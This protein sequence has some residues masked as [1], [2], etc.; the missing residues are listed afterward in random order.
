MTYNIKISATAYAYVG[1]AKQN[2]TVPQCLCE[3]IDNAIAAAKPKAKTQVYVALAPCPQDKDHVMVCV[4]DWGTGMDVEGL[5][6]ALQLGSVPTGESRLNEHGFGLDNAL[7][8]LTSGDGN[9]SMMSHKE[10]SPYYMVTGPMQEDMTVEE[11]PQ[12]ELPDGILLPANPATVVCARVSMRFLQT[13]RRGGGRCSDLATV[14][15]W[16]LEHLGVAYRGYL[17]LDEETMEPTAKIVLSIGEDRIAVAPNPVPMDNVTT[18]RFS[19]EIAGAIV[20]MTYRYGML[21]E[22]AR[23]HMVRGTKA[24]YYYQ[25]NTSTQGIDIRLGKRV[26]ATAQFDQIWRTANGKGNLARHNNYNDFVGEVLIPELPRGVLT[27][28]NNKTG[29]DP[30]DPDWDTIVDKLNDFTPPVKIREA[31]EQA[32]KEK[33]MSILAAACPADTISD[34]IAVWPTATRIDVVEEGAHGLLLYELK[35]GRGA[36]LDLYQMRMYWDGLVLSGRQPAQ[37]TLL[38]AEY[39]SDLS[40]MLAL[41]NQ[42]PPPKLP[43]GKSS[44][45]YCFSIARHEDKCLA[46]A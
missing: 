14:R 33:W 26:I 4:A 29:I 44:A 22:D 18:E 17:E 45:P 2:M 46:G 7:A 38:V 12:L 34:E 16:L 13:V 8:T 1:L 21:S 20:P 3:L 35:V 37:A 11:L 36:P 10:N 39:S 24:K 41:M 5:E 15:T 31:T 40:A 28:L 32:I 43:D 30:T 42:L 6:N 9:W 23:D 27:T 25:G 19:L